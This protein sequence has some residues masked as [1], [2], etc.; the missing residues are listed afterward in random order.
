[1]SAYAGLLAVFV[2][3][4]ANGFFVAAEFALVAVRRGTIEAR[5]REGDRRAVIALGELDRLSFV[6]SACQFGITATSLVVGFLAEDAFGAVLLPLLE[7]LGLGGANI[8]AVAVTLAFV[9]STFLQMLLGELAPKNLAIAEA[10]ATSLRVAR[11][12][13]L[14]GIVMG[15]VIRVFDDAAAWVSRVVFRLELQEERIGGH[16]P[17]E[18]ARIIS[19]SREEGSLNE[20]QGELLQRAVAIGDR[21][22][23]EVM[24]PRPD[25]RFLTGDDSCEDLRLTSRSTGHSRFPVR[26]ETDDDILGTAHIKDLLRIPVEERTDTPLTAIVTPPLVVPETERLRRLIGQLRAQR[27]T[28]AVVVD[29]YGGTAGIVTLEDVLEELVG[30]IEDEFDR[31]GGGHVRRVGAGRFLV[32]GGLRLDDVGRVTGLELPEGDYETVAGFVIDRLGHIPAEQ[33]VV[34]HDGWE[35]RVTRLEGVRVAEVELRRPRAATGEVA[36]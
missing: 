22:V 3:I 34:E 27:R 21:R 12:I 5:A 32:R 9:L 28:F 30:E 23:H 11:L 25:V 33:E 6:L 36:P 29:E 15:P 16:S 8:T 24:V 35:L 20:A 1:V 10:E 17:D 18:L 19:A 14:F 13:R 31:P 4:A 26:G 2:L 7:G